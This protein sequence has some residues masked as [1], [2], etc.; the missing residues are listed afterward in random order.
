MS[1]FFG[2]LLGSSIFVIIEFYVRLLF[3]LIESQTWCINSWINHIASS[4]IISK[5]ISNRDHNSKTQEGNF[6]PLPGFEPW[7]TGNK[8]QAAFKYLT[9]NL[10][11]DGKTYKAIFNVQ[12]VSQVVVF[13]AFKIKLKVKNNSGLKTNVFFYTLFFC[14]I[15]FLSV[16]FVTFIFTCWKVPPKFW[17]SK[18]RTWTRGWS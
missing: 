1:R 11:L 10:T 17:V 12:E 16:P 13:Y 4:G 2:L 6:S 8:I 18:V 9:E 3:N 15:V 14:P 5:V 7:T